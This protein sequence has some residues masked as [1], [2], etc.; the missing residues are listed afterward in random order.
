MPLAQVCS[1]LSLKR[2]DAMSRKRNNDSGFTLLELLVALTIFSMGLLSVAG[3][4]ITALRE[5]TNSHTR[6]AAAALASGILEEIQ[7]W[8]P[9]S[10]LLSDGS[11]TVWTFPDGTA[12]TS[13][14]GAGNFRAT[15]DVQRNFGTQ[16]VIRIQVNV[17][18][19]G[20]NTTLVG[21]K[22]AV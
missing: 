15:F 1:K 21:F 8:N 18:G 6:T 2:E 5:N 17:T 10:A 11:G 4:Q 13:L 9:D 22:R 14:P 12:V 3:M 19:G 7:R 20:R 16:N